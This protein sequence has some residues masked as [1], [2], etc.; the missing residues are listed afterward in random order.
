MC[1]SETDEEEVFSWTT[2]PNC[3]SSKRYHR[4]R[5]TDTHAIRVRCYKTLYKRGDWWTDTVFVTFFRNVLF[6]FGMFHFARI[7]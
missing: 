2:K 6:V 1:A 4:I 5:D 7:I 3:F